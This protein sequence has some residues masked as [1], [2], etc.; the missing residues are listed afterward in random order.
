MSSILSQILK[1]TGI[2][3]AER[4]DAGVMANGAGN[5]PV[6][7]SDG[8][9]PAEAVAAIGIALAKYERDLFEMGSAVLTIRRVA[10]V[11]S[12]WSHK[13]YGMTNQLNRK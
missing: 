8:D 7:M 11:N 13:I 1:K 12:P 3:R 2:C 10:H 6:V 5:P 9:I 4:E